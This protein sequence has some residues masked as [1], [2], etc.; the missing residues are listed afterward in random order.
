MKFAAYMLCWPLLGV[1][2]VMAFVTDGMIDAC[3]AMDCVL[4]KLEDYVESD[5]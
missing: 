3:E 1:F 2:A 5:A 4:E